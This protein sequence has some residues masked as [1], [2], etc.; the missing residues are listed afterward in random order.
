M[1]VASGELLSLLSSESHDGLSGAAPLVCAPL[2][3]RLLVNES[4]WSLNHVVP[5]ASMI[6]LCPR[7]LLKSARFLVGVARLPFPVVEYR[8][9][10]SES[11][12]DA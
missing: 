7:T 11:S 9:H 5:S 8:F 6:W 2:C 12:H 10:R 1:G 3:L 4:V